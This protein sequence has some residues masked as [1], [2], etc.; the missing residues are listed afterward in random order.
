M[1]KDFANVHRPVSTLFKWPN[2]KEEWKPYR[3]SDAQVAHFHEYG[4]L[5]NVKVLNED[6]IDVLRKDLEAIMDPEHPSH[7]LFYEFH[8]NESKDS[9]AILFH[10]LGHWRMTEAFHDL[11]WN[12]AFVMAAHQLLENKSVRFWHDQVFYKPARMVG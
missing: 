11:L 6:Q 5:D 1:I 8:S 3:L 9:D 7:S 4:Y 2:N 10:A 12:P